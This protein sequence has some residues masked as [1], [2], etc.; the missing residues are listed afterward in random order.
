M[1]DFK[2][3]KLPYEGENLIYLYCVSK[4][5]TMLSEI[6]MPNFNDSFFQ[7]LVIIPL[8]YQQQFMQYLKEQLT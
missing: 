1:Y 3:K 4:Y 5:P 2:N 6:E 8:V 7:D